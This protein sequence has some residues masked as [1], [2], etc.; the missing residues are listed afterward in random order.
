MTSKPDT[1][2]QELFGHRESTT[3]P[4]EAEVSALFEQYKLIVGTSEA[5]VSRR[6]QVNTFFLSIN[7]LILAA[8]GLLVRENTSDSIAGPAFVILG[9]S[10]MILCFAW[11]RMILSFRQLNRGKFDVIH[12]LERRL[13]ARIFAAEWDALGR[14]ED[15]SK[16]KPFTKTEIWLPRIMAGLELVVLVIGIGLWACG[17]QNSN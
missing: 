16:Y 10:G 13:P 11:S 4:N 7:S 15:P 1:V 8:I 3:P 2:E 14:G 5:L 17:L 9:M 12:A 6:Q